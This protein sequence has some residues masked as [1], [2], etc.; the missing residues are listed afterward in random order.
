[1]IG[2]RVGLGRTVLIDNHLEK[3]WWVDD[4]P[5]DLL[6]HERNRLQMGWRIPALGSR[7]WLGSELVT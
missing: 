4:I 1:M 2:T 5:L 6:E 3:D 7:A